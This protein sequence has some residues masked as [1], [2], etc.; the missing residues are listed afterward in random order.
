MQ[1]IL[2]GSSHLIYESP[3]KTQW[4]Q[5]ILYKSSPISS[6]YPNELRGF[7]KTIMIAFVRDGDTCLGNL[8]IAPLH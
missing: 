4:T 1:R 6:V 5:S 7:D 8:I 2:D 3:T